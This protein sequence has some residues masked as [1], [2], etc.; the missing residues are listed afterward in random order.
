MNIIS[1]IAAGLLLATPCCA[2]HEADPAVQPFQAHKKFA[3][4]TTCGPMGMGMEKSSIFRGQ[5]GHRGPRGNKGE[6]GPRGRCG[7]RG[8][9]GPGVAPAYI[10]RSLV[11]PTFFQLVPNS[12]MPLGN[13]DT[14]LTPVLLGYVDPMPSDPFQDRYIHVLPGGA[15]KT[16]GSCP[17]VD[18]AVTQAPSITDALV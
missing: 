5:R 2:T 9:Q 18:R 4:K 14:G 17:K 11:I 1:F 10:E 16:L 7:R 8:H 12:I 15:G 6:R 3:I 13:S